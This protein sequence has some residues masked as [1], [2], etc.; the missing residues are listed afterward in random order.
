MI[1][2]KRLRVVCSKCDTVFTAAELPLPVADL[3]SIIN[4]ARCP[5]CKT[6]A[7][8]SYLYIPEKSNGKLPELQVYDE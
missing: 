7:T 2:E 8:K 1:E 5:A 3:V 6:K 4:G